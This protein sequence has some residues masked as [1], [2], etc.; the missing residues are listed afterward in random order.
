[1]EPVAAT[2]ATPQTQISRNTPLPQSN[3]DDALTNPHDCAVYVHVPAGEFE[4][5]PDD[6]DQSQSAP[7]TYTIFVDDFWIGH[8][9]VTNAQ[10]A[11][12]VEDGGCASTGN[13]RLTDPAFANHPVAHVTW[14][15]ANDYARWVGGRLPT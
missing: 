3:L 1:Q 14:H 10:Y 11:R 9:E 15:Q 7:Q 13:E 5:G 12:C 6:S 2:I 8:T 4:M